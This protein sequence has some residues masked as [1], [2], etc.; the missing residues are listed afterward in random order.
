MLNLYLIYASSDSPT[1]AAYFST[2]VL[3][4]LYF[5]D[6][7]KNLSPSSKNQPSTQL[8]QPTPVSKPVTEAPVEPVLISIDE[9]KKIA[10]E[11]VVTEKPQARNNGEVDSAELKGVNWHVAGSWSESTPKS[12]GVTNFSVV[13]DGRSR[14]I[15]RVSYTAGIGLAVG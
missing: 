5:L 2:L 6:Q 1:R 4:A 15:L 14:R 10:L 7:F 12:Y 13:I 8:P 3:L 11:R 9:A